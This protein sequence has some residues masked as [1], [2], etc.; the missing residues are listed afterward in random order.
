MRAMIHLLDDFLD[1]VLARYCSIAFFHSF[2]TRPSKK[3]CQ[4]DSFCLLRSSCNHG[5]CVPTTGVSPLRHWFR[6]SIMARLISGCVLF[7]DNQ[8]RTSSI[9]R[10]HK[11]SVSLLHCQICCTFS[12]SPHLGQ[13]SESLSRRRFIIVPVAQNPEMV[14]ETQ[15]C[16][17]IGDARIAPPNAS[18]SITAGPHGPNLFFS[19]PIFHCR[20]CGT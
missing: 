20:G 14:F 8:L 16:R 11:S 7:S 18:Q 5:I 6:L 1:C 10:F 2:T 4:P 13:R 12:V 17:V 9:D 19:G 15:C 3:L